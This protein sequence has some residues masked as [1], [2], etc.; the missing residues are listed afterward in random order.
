MGAK[1][2]KLPNKAPTKL[3]SKELQSLEKQTGLSRQKIE[4]VFRKFN[5]NNP[6]RSNEI[7]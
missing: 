4:E 6:G 1:N 7:L 3:S 2:G 5:T